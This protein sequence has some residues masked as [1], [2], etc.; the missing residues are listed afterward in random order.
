MSTRSSRSKSRSK[1]GRSKSGRGRSGAGAVQA[2]PQCQMTAANATEF[3]RVLGLPPLSETESMCDRLAALFHLLKTSES[4]NGE[5]GSTLLY[6]WYP[7]KLL[8]FGERG[9]VLELVSTDDENQEHRVIKFETENTNDSK[10]QY[11]FARAGL[12]ADVFGH[13]GPFVFNDIP[14]WITVMQKVDGTI[15][16]WINEQPRT[17]EELKRLLDSVFELLDDTGKETFTHGDAHEGNIGY[18]GNPTERKNLV[19]IDFGYSSTNNVD[20][21]IDP[22]QLL[23]HTWPHKNFPEKRISPNWIVFR[24]LI[25]QELIRRGIISS[26]KQVRTES[27]VDKLWTEAFS[28]YMAGKAK[29]QRRH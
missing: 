1:S 21:Q 22:L 14:L 6:N 19:L 26:L 5:A 18:I 20:T 16:D 15:E 12:G 28:K 17:E 2:L 9:T 10:L 11:Q 25:K 4:K 24:K 3:Q 8:G 29:N 13:E 27:Q 23:R 7:T